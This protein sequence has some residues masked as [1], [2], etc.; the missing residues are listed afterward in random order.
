MH[1]YHNNSNFTELRNHISRRRKKTNCNLNFSNFTLQF[2]P[3]SQS[4]NKTKMYVP[5]LL[6]DLPTPVNKLLEYGDNTRSLKNPSQAH[7]HHPSTQRPATALDLTAAT[8]VLF[9]PDDRGMEVTPDHLTGTIH[10]AENPT[11]F[12]RPEEYVNHLLKARDAQQ[13]AFSLLRCKNVIAYINVD[14][15]AAC[16]LRSCSVHFTRA[17]PC[18]DEASLLF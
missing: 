16:L 14:L 4:I 10:S 1:C 3:I 6:L 13:S 17:D 15:P 12:R 11:I 18:L 7:W 5:F 8:N 9:V 2:T